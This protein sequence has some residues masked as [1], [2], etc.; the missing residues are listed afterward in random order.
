[1][2][3]LGRRWSV[4]TN[5]L[6]YLGATPAEDEVTMD[7]DGVKADRDMKDDGDVRKKKGKIADVA[8]GDDNECGENALFLARLVTRWRPGRHSG[9]IGRRFFLVDAFQCSLVRQSTRWR[10][11]L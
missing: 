5:I 2:V 7:V 11:I 1:M 9:Q 8:I 6:G 4:A 10:A 3:E